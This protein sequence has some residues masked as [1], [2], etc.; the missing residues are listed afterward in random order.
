MD[1]ETRIRALWDANAAAWTDAVRGGGIRSRR[2]ATDAAIVEAVLARQPRAVLDVGCGEGWL[3]RALAREGVDVLGV[4]GAPALIA[5]A[6]ASG[7]GRFQVLTQ[8]ALAEEG[9][10]ARFDGVVCNF[11]LFGKTVV[12]RLFARM[13]DLLQPRGAL[14]VQTLH[15]S[16]VDDEGARRDGWRDGSWQGCGDGFGEAP[17]WYF[18][19]L[20]GW[21]Q[22]IEASGMRL[23]EYR[24]PSDPADGRPLSLL[25]IATPS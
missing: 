3:A 25:L 19:T 12:E 9:L 2:V 24:E 17:P 14:I 5:Q 11:A 21:R 6:Q 10:D 16:A 20:D 22:L 23:I 7:A 18:R 4:D 15:P 13:P 8:E 1:R